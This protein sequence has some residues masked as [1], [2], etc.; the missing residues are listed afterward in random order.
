MTLAPGAVYVELF[1]DDLAHHVAIFRDGL[2]FEI[3]ED[4]GEFVKLATPT[5]L[6]M[7]NAERDLDDDHPFAQL[8]RGARRG[9]GCELVFVV[10]DVHRTREK[11]CVIDG[12]APTAI[13]DQEWGMSDF[14]VTTR[15][16]YYLRV[17]AASAR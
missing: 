3:V 9:L 2:G 1:V 4:E 15:D 7:L 14:R 12:C 10:A 5:A 13:V 11:M 6:V 17:T 16:G 8:R